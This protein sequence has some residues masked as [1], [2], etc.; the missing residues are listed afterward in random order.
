MVANS[1]PY[2]TL[3]RTNG[4]RL[5]SLASCGCV[6]ISFCQDWTRSMQFQRS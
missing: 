2:T 6:L 3:L 4:G 5:F 1:G